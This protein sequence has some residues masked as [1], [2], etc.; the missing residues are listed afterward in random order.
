MID[1]TVFRTPIKSTDGKTVHLYKQHPGCLTTFDPEVQSGAY[2]A[3]DVYQRG[4]SYVCG[5]LYHDDNDLITHNPKKVTCPG[6][7]DGL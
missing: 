5:G 7:K 2:R 6:C 1:K 4:S 3:A